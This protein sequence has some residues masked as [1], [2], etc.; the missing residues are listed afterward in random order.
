MEI[1][2]KIDDSYR[3]LIPLELRQMFNLSKHQEVTL[4]S[5]KENNRIILAPKE[6]CSDEDISEPGLEENEEKSDTEDLGEE[7]IPIKIE[8]NKLIYGNARLP[9][10]PVTENTRIIDEPKI[11]KFKPEDVLQFITPTPISSLSDEDLTN[12]EF[13]PKCDGVVEPN[14]Y[15]KVNGRRICMSCIQDLKIQLKQDI[16][17]K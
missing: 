17:N 1:I 11:D 16:S 14:S 5:D 9:I 2:R 8:D 15:I 3:I 4:I 7:N 10:K 12:L 6:E 13:C